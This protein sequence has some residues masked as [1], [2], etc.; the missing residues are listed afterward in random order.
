MLM[1]QAY[2]TAWTELAQVFNLALSPGEVAA[3]TGIPQ[4]AAAAANAGNAPAAGAAA[5]FPSL[6]MAQGDRPYGNPVSASMLPIGAGA[7][8]MILGANPKRVGLTIQNNSASGGATFWI[9]FGVPATQNLSLA[10]AP[11]VGLVRDG[12][13]PRDAVYILITGPSGVTAGAIEE[14]SFVGPPVPQPPI[15]SP[16]DWAT[17][18]TGANAWGYGDRAAAPP[19]LAP[20]PPA[21]LWVAPPTSAPASS[22]LSFATAL[23]GLDFTSLGLW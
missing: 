17:V 7:S 9:S 4:S 18:N 6:P 13:V 1:P 23:S 19:P 3:I 10:L 5:S 15:M 2:D 14:D 21:S 11:G 16:I 20:A 22:S 8:G 12:A